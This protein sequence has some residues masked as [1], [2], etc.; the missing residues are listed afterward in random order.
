[1][2][3]IAATDDGVYDRLDLE[4][5]RQVVGYEPQDGTAVPRK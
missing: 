2:Y 3:R 1:M 4:I 5:S